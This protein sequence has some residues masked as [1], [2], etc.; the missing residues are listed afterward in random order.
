MPYI[1]ATGSAVAML[2]PQIEDDPLMVVEISLSVRKLL[3]FPEG[4]EPSYQLSE[5]KRRLHFTHS[6]DAFIPV[7]VADAAEIEAF[8]MREVLVRIAARMGSDDS[9]AV[10]GVVS[11][12]SGKKEADILLDGGVAGRTSADGTTT[13]RNVRVGPR[14]VGLRDPAGHETRKIARVEPGRTSLVHF[15]LSESDGT[16]VSYRLTSLGRNAQG[17]DE[18][19]RHADGA[20]VVKVPSGEFLMGNKETE[21]TPLEHRVNVSEFLI[22]KTG[23]TWGQFKKFAEA[24]GMPMPPHEPYWGV[25]D[26]HPAVFV[27]WEEARNYCAWVGG[28]LPTE[29][30]REKAARGTDGR[31]YPWGNEEPDPQRGV[32]RRTW[33][34]KATDPVGSHPNGASPYGVQDLGGNVWEWCSDWYDDGYYAISPAQDPKGPASGQTH[35]ARGGSWDS[36]PSVLSS[37]CRN[38]GHRGY[39]EGDFGFR[40][41]MSGP[42]EH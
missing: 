35:V 12:A 20:V 25:H 3:A 11:I 26:D 32:F 16:A 30:E 42:A 10:Y 4:Q 40:C 17:Y 7:L 1:I 5:I 22:D 27:T 28:R 37:S 29:A 14:E 8:G 36:R 38:W 24:T 18:Y 6:R 23:V 9:A 13:L 2:T 33:G 15:G 31:K 19:R 34:Y 39:R 41:A 21:R